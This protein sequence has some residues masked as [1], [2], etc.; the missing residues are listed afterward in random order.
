[1]VAPSSQL[2]GRRKLKGVAWLILNEIF[3]REKKKRGLGERRV[4]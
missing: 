1:M 2:L 4:T 3:K